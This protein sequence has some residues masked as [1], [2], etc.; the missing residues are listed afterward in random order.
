MIVQGD[1]VGWPWVE[2]GHTADPYRRVAG[3]IQK[4][5]EGELTSRITL[6]V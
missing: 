1:R 4:G 6:S 2:A 3:A 5:K